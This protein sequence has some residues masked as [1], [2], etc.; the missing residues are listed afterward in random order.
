MKSKLLAATLLVGTTA[1]VA[2]YPM[3]PSIG[4]IDPPPT[5]PPLLPQHILQTEQPRIDVVF[6]LDTT[7]SMEGLIQ[8]AKEKIWSIASTMA[9]AQQAPRIRMGLVAYRD[10]GDSYVTEIVDLSEDLDSM[11]ARLMDLQADGGGD[12]PESVNQALYDAVHKV[13]WTQGKDAYKA[14]FLVGDAPPHMD[15]QDDVKYPQTLAVAASQGIVVNAIQCGQGQSTRQQW[16]QI[17]RLGQGNYFQVEQSGSAVAIVTPFDRTLAELSKELDETRIYYGTESEKE[18][19]QQKV[20]AAAKLH[21]ESSDASR[22]RRAAFNASPSG[23]R[24]LLGEGELV[25]DVASGRVDIADLPPQSLPAPMQSMKPEDR[26]ALIDQTAERRGELQQ[27]IEVLA[28]Q[29]SHYLKK[30][31]S[32]LGGAEDSL[33]HQIYSAVREQAEA[34]GLRYDAD[35][36]KY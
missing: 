30:Q 8:A 32:E 17:A 9:S 22:A 18:A 15:Y 27:R 35:A 6:V 19:R 14:V 7:G 5:I 29:R 11:Y 10:R 28:E 3:P 31:I 12:G 25:D 20:D 36:L 13:S 34:K 21:D 16:Q 4:A 26:R 2:F 23:A 33:D 24:N 1:T